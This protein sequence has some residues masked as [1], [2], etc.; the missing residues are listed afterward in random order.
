MTYNGWS[1]Y[2]TWAVKLWLDNDEDD[3]RHWAR[4]ASRVSDAR[5]LADELKEAHEE[6]AIE[7]RVAPGG[8]FGDLLTH[9]LGQVNWHEI[10]ESFIE[11]VETDETEEDES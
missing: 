9:A 11:D 2:E 4:C 3:Q 10:A 7:S 1:N 8:V 6:L 5:Q